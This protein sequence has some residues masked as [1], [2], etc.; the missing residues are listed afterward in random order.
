MDGL[1]EGWMEVWKE[2]SS[3]KDGGWK[4]GRVTVEGGRDA[5]CWSHRLLTLP[6]AMAVGSRLWG[7]LSRQPFPMPM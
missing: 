5:G 2:L 4:D 1:M 6:L 7:S 3:R